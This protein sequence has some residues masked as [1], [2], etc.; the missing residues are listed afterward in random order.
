MADEQA[1]IAELLK[2]GVAILAGAV[3][4]PVF[5]FLSGR[6]KNTAEAK[7]IELSSERLT[8]HDLREWMDIAQLAT[9][10]MA[11]L[12][13]V[14]VEMLPYIDRLPDR[15]AERLQRVLNDGGDLGGTK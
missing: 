9:K 10:R 13:S 11:R 15:T 12:E 7:Q 4:K 2:L 3:I 1:G 14:L 5:D 6:R 8:Q